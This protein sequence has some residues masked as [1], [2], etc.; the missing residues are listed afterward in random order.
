M[1]CA[2]SNPYCVCCDPIMMGYVVQV[3]HD[4]AP[5]IKFRSLDSF[6]SALIDH[7]DPS[8]LPSEF[9]DPHRTTSDVEIAQRLHEQAAH[10]SGD[11]QIEAFRFAICLLSADQLSE[12]AALLE[13]PNFE[14]SLNAEERLQALDHPQAHAALDAF[15]QSLHDFTAHSVE[16][17]TAAGFAPAAIRD[18]E[19]LLRA[20]LTAVWLNLRA[21]YAERTLHPDVWNYLVAQARNLLSRSS[22]AK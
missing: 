18:T 13:F 1:D 4:D 2:D 17:L 9:D 14:V 6:F 19:I 12:I 22:N 11:A 15:E 20:E 8:T 21:F 3:F 5:Q 7:P 10:L 16:V